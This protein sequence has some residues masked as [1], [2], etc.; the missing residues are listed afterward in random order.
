[1]VNSVVTGEILGIYKCANL[2]SLA[3][4]ASDLCAKE[5]MTVRRTSGSLSSVL[6]GSCRLMAKGRFI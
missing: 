5:R 4:A 3:L 1:M 2:L 6:P